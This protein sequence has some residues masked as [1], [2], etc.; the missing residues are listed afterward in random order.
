MKILHLINRALARLEGWLIVFFL[1]LMVFF[2]FLQIMLRALYTHAHWSLANTM[3]GMVDWTEPLVRL[4]VLWIT[5]FGASLLT[6]EQKH[7]RID[8][9]PAL[10]AGKRINFRDLLINLIGAVISAIMFKTSLNYIQLEMGFGSTLFLGLP[11]WIGQII[12]PLGFALIC[13]RFSINCLEQTII[14]FRSNRS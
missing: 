3:L 12:L 7:I 11:S 1:S 8:I 14:L 9:V 13:F 5:F 4:L 10:F 2:T 6:R